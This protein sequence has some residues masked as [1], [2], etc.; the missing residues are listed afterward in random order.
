VISYCFIL[1]YFGQRRILEYNYREYNYRISTPNNQSELS[2]SVP[3][4]I[5]V[6]TSMS[7]PLVHEIRR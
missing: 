1:A 6:V 3:L 4:M 5:K 7:K 2:I